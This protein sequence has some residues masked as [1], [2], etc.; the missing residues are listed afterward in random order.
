MRKF[1]RK[2]GRDE[3]GASIIE[4]AMVTPVFGGLLIGMV[5]I[6]RAYSAKLQLEQSAYRAIE[7]VQ[8]YQASESTY[9]TLKSE[10]GS[11]ARAAGFTSVA[12]SDV[13]LDFW[14]ECNGARQ[15]NYDTVCPTGQ[16]YARWVTVDIPATFTPMFTSRRWPGA[17]ANGTFTLHGR[18]GLRTQ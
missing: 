1:L 8:Q 13:T 5:D 3:R 15:A 10:A 14:L 17:N 7:K 16:V 18:A 4:M 2:I 11:A 6:S 12:D 9:T